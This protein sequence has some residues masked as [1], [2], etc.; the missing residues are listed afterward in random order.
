MLRILTIA[1]V[2]GVYLLSTAGV[3]AQ[4]KPVFR[5]KSIEVLKR[6][7]FGKDIAHY[8]Q[9]LHYRIAFGLNFLKPEDR[10]WW[11]DPE[12]D[13]SRQ[14]TTYFALKGPVGIALAKFNWFNDGPNTFRSDARLPASLA[15]MGAVLTGTCLPTACLL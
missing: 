13:K 2:A 14:A 9:L 10:R 12:K 8:H 1:A 4:E 11:G 7:T 6:T 3:W 15:A 5:A